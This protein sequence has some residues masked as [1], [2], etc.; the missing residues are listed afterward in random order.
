MKRLALL[1]FAWLVLLDRADGVPA[2]LPYEPE[3]DPK[4]PSI[5]MVDLRGT[6]WLGKS[7]SDNSQFTFHHDGTLTY[8]R[9][10]AKSG[11]KGSWKLVGNKLSYDVNQYSF[12]HG[13]VEGDVI[14]GTTSNKAGM[15][16]QV[17]LKRVS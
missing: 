1:L 7:F 3:E 4:P 12:F 10:G 6:T 9:K 15:K 16:T 8:S 13:T 2:R 5:R 17:Y 14:Q 11:S